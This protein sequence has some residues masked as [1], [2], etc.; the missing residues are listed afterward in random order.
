MGKGP[1]IVGAILDLL[2]VAVAITVVVLTSWRMLNVSV[3]GTNLDTSCVLDGSGS[4]DLISGTNFCIYAILV[5]VVSLLAL[6]IFKF[7]RKLFKCVTLNACSASR[8]VSIVGD[9]LQSAWWAVAFALFLRRGTAANDLDLPN[10]TE[11]D[12]IIACAFGGM[13]F[14][15]ADVLTG[16]WDMKSSISSK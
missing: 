3:E 10:Q 1:A 5:G 14:F 2:E 7:V 6:G 8:L 15:A 12:A 4:D 9:V 11:R 16:I 13:L